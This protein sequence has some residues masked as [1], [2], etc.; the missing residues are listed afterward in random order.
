MAIIN[1]LIQVEENGTISFGNYELPKKTKVMGFEVE[2]NLYDIRTF[3]EITKLNKDEALVYESIPGTAVHNF[4]VKDKLISFKVAGI[5]ESQ[6]TMELSPDTDYN[7][8]IDELKVGK[9]KANLAG[10]IV[11]SV[12]CRNTPKKVEIRRV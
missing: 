9:I 12:D 7:L 8:F 11:F 6:I 4:T 5:A 2:G 10:K 3:K 1:E